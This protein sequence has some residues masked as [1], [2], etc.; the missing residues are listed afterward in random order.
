[1]FVDCVQHRRGSIYTEAMNPVKK[2]ID[3]LAVLE[4]PGTGCQGG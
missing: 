4:A 3:T 2:F 1:M